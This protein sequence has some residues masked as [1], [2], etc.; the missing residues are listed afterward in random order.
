M[1]TWTVR[2]FAATAPG[3]PAWEFVDSA[4]GGNCVAWTDNRLECSDAVGTIE[5][6]DTPG[7]TGA[8]ETRWFR[9]DLQ[10]LSAHSRVDRW[11]VGTKQ[12]VAPAPATSVTFNLTNGQTVGG[13]VAVKMT[14]KGLGAGPYSWVSSV[15]GRQISSRRETVTSITLFWDT[16]GVANG[17]HTFSVK[18]TDA[19]GK[20][21]TG[22]VNVL[23]KN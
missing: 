19:A 17:S 11:E 14:A 22:S 3:D 21:A 13:T 12:V 1:R 20:A 10:G 8:L 6:F 2:P 15:D 7:S 9:M 23:V 16:R 5:W 4:S 18:V